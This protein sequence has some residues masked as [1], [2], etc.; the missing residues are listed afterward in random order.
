MF[1]KLYYLLYLPFFITCTSTVDNNKA[2]AIK[3]NTD[4]SK[5]VISDIREAQLYQLK[6]NLPTDSTYQKLVTVLQ[7]PAE[8]DSAAL[9]QEIDGKLSLEGNNLI[10]IPN[11]PF[12]KGKSYLVQSIIN[13]S[14]AT[15]KDMVKSDIGHHL[16][17]QSV[18]LQR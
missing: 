2:L 5:I 14:F 17:A 11:L 1:K 16:K 6:T 10:F 18:L 3:F 8:D 9:E 12:S 4:S 15:R 7:T 13:S